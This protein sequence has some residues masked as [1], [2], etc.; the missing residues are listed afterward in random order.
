MSKQTRKY[1]LRDSEPEPCAWIVEAKNIKEATDIAESTR[2][3][4]CAVLFEAPDDKLLED[5]WEKCTVG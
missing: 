3:T 1:L 5:K 2:R 4:V